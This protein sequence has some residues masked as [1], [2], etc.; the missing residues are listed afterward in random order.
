MRESAYTGDADEHI[1]PDQTPTGYA[2]RLGAKALGGVLIHAAGGSV[3]LG[4]LIQIQR[5]EEQHD[6]A[7][8][9]AEPSRVARGCEHQR[10]DQG[11]GHAGGDER[12]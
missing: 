8:E 6:R 10:N 11:R 12:N 7:E 4:E 9:I 3:S 1:R 5:D 2:A